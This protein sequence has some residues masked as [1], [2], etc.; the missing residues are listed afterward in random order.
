MQRANVSDVLQ[1]IFLEDNQVRQLSRLDG[2]Q[3]L[4]LVDELGRVDGGRLKNR[5]GW[6]TGLGHQFHFLPDGESGNGVVIIVGTDQQLP[7]GSRELL[8]K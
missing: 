5:K 2:P 4:L 1:G 6:S 8:R 3:I 7:A